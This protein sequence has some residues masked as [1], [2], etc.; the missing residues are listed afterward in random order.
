LGAVLG[1][2]FT[3][4]FRHLWLLP[5]A[6]CLGL[7]SCLGSAFKLGI[8]ASEN[9]SVI[10]SIY[11][12]LVWGASLKLLAHSTIR[13]VSHAFRLHSDR[14]LLEQ[15][16]HWT[17][18][19]ITLLCLIIPIGPIGQYGLFNTPLSFLFSLLI[20]MVFLGLSGYRYQRRLHSYLLLGC[21]ALGVV[22]CYVRTIH[23]DAIPSGPHWL[24]LVA[25][26]G[27]GLVLTIIS[28]TYW[29]IARHAESRWESL[30]TQPL[31]LMAGLT[32][33]WALLVTMSLFAML[34]IQ[35]DA[36]LPWLFLVLSLALIPV[37]QPL[38]QAAAMRGMGVA[39]LLTGGV[40][41]AL[42]LGGWSS[43]DRLLFVTWAY[44]IWGLGNFVLPRYNAR[45]PNWCI[46]PD[47]WP[48]YGLGIVGIALVR[49]V[50]NG[51]AE[52]GIA[53]SQLGGY[54]T[55]V[56]FYLFLMLRHS[57]WPGFPW[58]A[59]LA[60]MCA[61]LAYNIAWLWRF[62]FGWVLPV[63]MF[64]LPLPF[65]FVLG[66]GVWLNGLLA[67]AFLWRRYGHAVASRLSWQYDELD[68]PL[69]WWPSAVLRLGVVIFAAM[70]AITILWSMPV[71]HLTPWSSSVLM[72]CVL[73]L[74]CLHMLGVKRDSRSSHL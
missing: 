15:T 44:S 20:G 42:A 41:S 71:T 39:L 70:Q 38:R 56:S 13:R 4:Y 7:A 59:V 45:C 5:L 46:A 36:A 12:A 19:A 8:T 33:G 35:V 18:F 63:P 74:S 40:V 26:P 57:A 68:R 54:L 73:T 16:T 60:L 69:G 72:G 47:T 9:L 65:C 52:S 34:P 43:V 22:L 66:A 48:W 11:A 28:L 49:W 58:L 55:A 51:A 21:S 6:L 1:L 62:S 14:S 53:A 37:S 30:Y 2:L 67:G 10:G 29:V 31:R 24:T 27:L 3:G 17:A 32:Y 50:V 25:D 23:A 64:Y 61:G